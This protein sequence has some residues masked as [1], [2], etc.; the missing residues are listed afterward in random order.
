MDAA[1]VWSLMRNGLY[2]DLRSVKPENVNLVWIAET[3]AKTPRWG[4]RHDGA[5]ISVA[6]HCVIGS[7]V[8]GDLPQKST[9]PWPMM[10]LHWLLH[11]AHEAWIGDI[12]QPVAEALNMAYPNSP[13]ALLKHSIDGA[14]YA[15]LDLP[16]PGSAEKSDIKAMDRAMARVEARQLFG[17][18]IFPDACDLRPMTM[19]GWHADVA[20][21]NWL[22]AMRRGLDEVRNG[23]RDA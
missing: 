19:P 1:P 17:A 13:L 8:F 11:D 16:M 5:P 2:E 6:E 7:W 10:R 20:A 18:E 23:G 21:E 3:L 22:S 15:K 9:I 4:A 14:I 12:Q